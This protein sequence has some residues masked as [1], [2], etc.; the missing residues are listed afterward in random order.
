MLCHLIFI[1][2]INKQHDA[3]SESADVATNEREHSPLCLVKHA[4]HTDMSHD[5]I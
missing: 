1:I 4:D 2:H 3:N 5:H